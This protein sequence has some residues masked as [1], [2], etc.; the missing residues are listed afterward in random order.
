MNIKS[1]IALTIC[2]GLSTSCTAYKSDVFS[3]VYFVK[4]EAEPAEVASI[5]AEISGMFEFEILHVYDT[6]SEGFSVRIP[7]LIVP[8]LEK[9]EVVE[10]ITEDTRTD[11]AVPIDPDGNVVYG[12]S[13]LPVGILRINGPYMGNLDLSNI[14]VAVIDTGIDGAHNDLNVVDYVDIVAQSSNDSAPDGDPNG[15]GTHVAGTIGALANGEGVAGVAPG[16]SLHA[17]RVLDSYGSGYFS[18]IIA[19]IE[20]VLEN[21]EIRVVNMSLGASKSAD[22]LPIRDAIQR[23]EESGVVV[24]IAAGNESQNTD[25]VAPAAYNQGIVVSA[26]DLGG[27]TNSYSDRGFAWFSNYGD[28]VDISAPGVSVQS[29]WPGGGMEILDGTSMATPH[30][31]GAVAVYRA[32]DADATPDEIRANLISSGEND[33]N[34]QTGPNGDHPEPLL[35]LEVFWSMAGYQ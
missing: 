15:H 13:E 35:N 33:Y 25:N 29:T 1:L 10:S 11:Y 21:P 5:V 20:Y 34:G 27:D 7:H 32:Y 8:E 6:A 9:L 19:G 17:V 12:D 24:C 14:H 30:V 28:A 26:Y 18:D 23:L 4:L 16:V 3:G 2:T 31:A 22:T